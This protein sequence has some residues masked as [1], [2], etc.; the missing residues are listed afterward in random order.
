MYVLGTAVVYVVYSW[1]GYENDFC[2]HKVFPTEQSAKEY[3]Q[4]RNKEECEDFRDGTHRY[5][6]EVG[7]VDF[8]ETEGDDFYYWYSSTILVKPNEGES[9]GNN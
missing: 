8:N 1:D 5:I 4:K 7:N 3:C 9:D 2:I 6:D